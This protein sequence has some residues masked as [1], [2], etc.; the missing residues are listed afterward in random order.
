MSVRSRAGDTATV[1]V[2]KVFGSSVPPAI[3]AAEARAQ[4]TPSSPFSPGT[5]IGPY[6]G[7][8]RQ[9]RAHDFVT[10]YNI[11]T[12][13][14]THERVSFDTLKGL[15]E[16]YDVAQIAIWHRIDSIRSLDWKLVAADHYD[17]DVKDAV[18]AGMA[19][20]DKPDRENTF[21]AWLA[22]W[23]YDVLAYDA[24][25]LYRLRNRGGRAVGLGVVDGTSIAPLLDY[26]GN[27]PMPPAEAYVQYANGLPWNWL[28]QDDLIYQ[29]FRPRSNSPYGHAPLESILLNA[30]TDIRFQLYFLQRFTDGNLP[31]AFASAPETWTPD[32]IEQFQEYWD[33]FMLGDQSRKHQIR[34][35]PGGSSFA[36][37]DEKEFTDHFSLFLMRKTLAAYHVVPS[38]VG[39][40]ENVN[41]SSGESQADVSHKVG[42]APLV[43][44]VQRVITGFL[45]DDLGLPLKHAF[46]LGEE[47]ADRVQQAQADKIYVDMG[48]ISASA[49]GEMRY[50]TSDPQTI[51]RYIFTERSGPIPLASLF[52]VAGEIDQATGL[53]VQGAPLPQTVFGG[54][55]GV[56]PNP[57]I[58]VM[59]LAE[60]E[61]GPAAMPPA[62]P[63][64]PV[65]QAPGP[66]PGETV[67]KEGE[68]APAA[69]ITAD[70]GI[71]SY[72]LIGE[73]DDEASPSPAGRAEVKKELND[74]RSH[75]RRH[76]R[77]GTWRDFTFRAVRPVRAH[78]LNDAGRAAVRKAAG[79][80]V[81]AGLAVLALDTGRVLM[82]QRALD[83]KDPAA[84]K[85]EFPG[86]HVED[87]ES[88]LHAAWREWSEETG[89]VPPPGEQ[90]GTWTSGDGVYQGIV[91]AAESEA[92]VPVRGGPVVP[93]PDDPD[94]DG[95]EAIL[96]LDPADLPG[97][98]M[99]RDEL[100]ASLGDV[101]PLLGRQAEGDEATCPCGTPVVYDEADG[102]Q[103]S[104]GSI[105]H[106]DGESVSDKMAAIA[107]AGDGKGPKSPGPS[108][109]G[110]AVT[111]GHDVPDRR[112][113]DAELGRQVLGA[114]ALK[115]APTDLPDHVIGQL[116]P[117]PGLVRGAV[118]LPGQVAPAVAPRLAGD[119]GPAGVGR[120]AD[121]GSAGLLGSQLRLDRPP[122]GPDLGG[123]GAEV[124]ASAPLQDPV[125][126]VGLVGTEEEVVRPHAGRVVAVMANQESIGDGAVG[127]LPRHAVGKQR[128]AL[129]VSGSPHP[130]NAVVPTVGI[131]GTH[132]LPAAGTLVH[133]VPETGNGGLID[134]RSHQL[135]VSKADENST[136]NP[137][138]W[139]GWK[140]D[141]RAA[142]YW[143]PYVTASAQ[144]SLTPDAL[145]EIGTAYIA[146]NPGQDGDAPGKRD[147]NAAALAW[148]KSRGVSVPMGDVAQG[149]TADAAMIGGTSA[150]A[151]VNGD[152][153]ADTG[154]WEPGD[155][156]TA[157][158]VTEGLGVA[159]VLALMPGGDGS[160]G[161][162]AADVAD[163]MEDGYLNVVARVLAGWDP[164][165]AADEL[166]D[167]LAESVADG[168]Y[169]EALTVTEITT[170]SGQAAGEYYL[171]TT[172]SPL[173]WVAVI[174]SRTCPSCLQ[175][176]AADPR[177]Y[178]DPWPAGAVSPPQHPGGC[179]C[180]LVPADL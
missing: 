50:G 44:Y 153:T 92:C 62:P 144:Q 117:V 108:G 102:W 169:A 56:L 85:L 30:N 42:E 156:A 149:V 97:N 60:Q 5:P 13:P 163:A 76:L 139:P 57:P 36:W 114:L 77:Q 61:F 17:G 8:S 112:L 87:G 171:A 161:G 133:P 109:D 120:G 75:R 90:A 164:D 49:I 179:R 150:K 68:G 29:P 28:T 116:D 52:A 135:I 101:L 146:A 143:Q 24:G 55:E 147:R 173:Q 180:A 4:M 118:E 23:L 127:D 22:E 154:D 21:E 45:Q 9:P 113:G 126:G 111:P 140:L 123:R 145:H 11:A 159:A 134:S 69:G 35:V 79:E 20:L 41:R 25:T 165:V 160:G 37:S 43:R 142:G 141:L 130:G 48:A 148:L 81:A 65:L 46:D 98:P 34:W 70:T 74:F 58:K 172:K 136:N 168:A 47:Q 96:W 94:G 138:G 100:A 2:A 121:A 152:D 78:R 128:L 103:H 72:D 93:N 80:L 122:H 166:A 83:D 14:R 131:P 119:N 89:C 95:A 64:Q 39:F 18:K 16:A 167:M 82:L 174:D 51:P 157:R 115:A 132:P 40:T 73:D 86:G 84:G 67:A 129:G 104:D 15:I 26:W 1:E 107:K 10:G 99:V 177:R 91:W 53:P 124:R 54:T 105:S 19:A 59:S 3:E 27:K 38:D 71:Y 162:A 6:D 155:P 12:R 151:A 106:D 32:Q 158:Q 176:A 33:G 110:R 178:G 66:L 137:K 175:N 88:A 7:F 63:P 31:H 170:V 125:G